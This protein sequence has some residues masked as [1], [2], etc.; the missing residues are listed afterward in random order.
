MLSWRQLGP[1]VIMVTECPSEPRVRQLPGGVWPFPTGRDLVSGQL[2]TV[3]EAAEPTTDITPLRS[4][5]P[6][7][8]EW[9]PLLAPA[10]LRAGPTL[11]VEMMLLQNTALLKV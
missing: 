4:P 5:Q 8:Q 9:Q 11:H 1:V 2:S 3:K 6:W 10:Q 7:P